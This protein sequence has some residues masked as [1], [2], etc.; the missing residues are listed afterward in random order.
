M[1]MIQEPLLLSVCGKRKQSI[2]EPGVKA[3]PGPLSPGPCSQVPG[4]TR[5]LC[6][7]PARHVTLS[8]AGHPW[9]W[10]P[11]PCSLPSFIPLL[12]PSAQFCAL[13]DGNR[14]QVV[15][16]FIVLVLSQ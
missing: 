3:S 10:S 14:I 2:E 11:W 15:F 1:D 9:K 7:L 4:W 12:I 8:H 16:G 6:I 13:K 5:A